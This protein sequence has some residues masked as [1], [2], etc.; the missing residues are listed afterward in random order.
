VVGRFYFPDGTSVQVHVQA[1]LTEEHS[2]ERAE[3]RVRNLLRGGPRVLI[4]GEDGRWRGYSADFRAAAGAREPLDDPEGDF[5]WY[6]PGTLFI[7]PGDWRV[8]M[9]S[10]T[11]KLATL[12]REILEAALAMATPEAPQP[13][14]GLDHDVLS[15]LTEKERQG[16][17]DTLLARPEA[18]SGLE[19]DAIHLLGRVVLAMPDGEFPALERRLTSGE[20]LDK[21]LG[22]NEPAKVLLGRAF[23]QKALASFPLVLEPLDSLPTF[24]LEREGET[25]HLLNVSAG[26]VSTTRVA[27]EAWN[28]RQGVRLGAEPA[29]SG[30]TVGAARRM[31]LYFQPVRQRFQMRYFSTMEEGQRSHALH[32][33]EWVRVEVHGQEP[34]THLMTAMELAL[35]A[36]LP[37][38]ALL[39][40][41]LG[42]I[43]E[44]HMAYGAVSTLARA[45][46]PAGMAATAVEGGTVAAAQR[47]AVGQFV[48]HM[49]LVTSLAVVDTWRDELSRSPEGRAFLA[50][51]D[52]A[53]LALA[54]RDISKL[55]TSGIWR[56]LAHRGG[57]L[58]SQSGARASAGLRDS[59]E[60][61]QAL[62]KTLEQML[63]GGKAVAT[64]EGLRLS[65]PGGAEA[66]KHAF[67]TIR[68][69]MAA[70]RA[71]GGIRKAGLAAEEAEK[72]LQ[73]LKVLAAEGQEMARAYSA[74]TRRAAALP[75]DKARAYLAA[76]EKLRAS[77]R[78]NVKPALTQLLRRSGA[79]SLTNPLAFLKE[80]EWL[81]GH[82]EL[83]VEAVAKLAKKA[84]NDSVDL[85][86]LRSTGLPLEDL[87]FMARNEKTPWR[88]F[89]RA[90]AKPGNSRV[91]LRAREQLRGIAVEMLTERDARRL[92]PGFRVVGRQVRMKEG[93]IIDNEIMAMHGMRL[94]HGV[95]AKGWNENR[96]RKALDAWR[97]K[98]VTRKLDEKQEA[99]VE[100]LQ[101]LL[102]QL[103]DAAKA[104]RGN[105][106]LVSTDKLSE[107]TRAKLLVFLARN[108]QSTK[109]IQL[110][111]A[112]ILEKT[113]QLRAAFKLPEDLSGGVP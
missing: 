65:L 30:E 38:T 12:R 23:T 61:I 63:A 46:L 108:A 106:F 50:V 57:L 55:A 86:W 18:T 33:L 1:L 101:R 11:G 43:G 13:L 37:D 52:V 26:L 49:S 82:P 72:T 64:P 21:L 110:D 3:L 28:P 94:R 59:V 7:R 102:D 79:P 76:V 34:R 87:N 42:R 16:L 47:T 103:A 97:A 109:L 69:E 9:G 78:G 6:Y 100:Q 105:P 83:D 62:A 60:S 31:A 10:G 40:A 81:V 75:A 36:S 17:F 41:A 19:E 92:F 45:P 51:H 20:V 53:L 29:L 104:P 74:V 68:G 2:L 66:F 84:C 24:H 98:Q 70:A 35:L 27:P 113:K 4:P 25:T 58:L 56:E 93:H 95:E 91:Q 111:E 67:F 54:G 44:M 88:L 96:W 80:A 5:Y 73:A 71:L 39:W 32:P 77:A 14:Y 107:P 85:G 99:L 8:G 48:G 15:L 90:G 89:R 22:G 112:R